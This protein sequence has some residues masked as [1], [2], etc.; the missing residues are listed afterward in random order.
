MT[1]GGDGNCFY[2]SAIFGYLENIILER[3]IVKLKSN[4]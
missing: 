1:I 2:K 4:Y 3:D